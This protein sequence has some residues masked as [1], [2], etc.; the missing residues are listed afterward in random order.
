MNYDIT[1]GVQTV[2]AAGAVTGT[3]NTSAMSATAEYTLFVTITGLTAGAT[4]TIQIQDTASSTAF[5][6]AETQ[7]TFTVG[8]PVVPHATITLSTTK[9][10]VGTGVHGL[11]A[12]TTDGT[13]SPRFGAANNSLRAYVSALTG[14]SPSLSLHA[15]IQQG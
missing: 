14:T 4:A 12:D 10:G 7:A 5:S 8:G 1:T 3:L 9:K 11:A 15:F 13:T 6:D 2:T